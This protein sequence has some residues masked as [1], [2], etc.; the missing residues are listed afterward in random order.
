[1]KV[2]RAIR[3]TRN[4]VRRWWW[5]A[6]GERQR[7]IEERDQYK[8]SSELRFRQMVEYRDAVYTLKVEHRGASVDV[9]RAVA[10]RIDCEPG[11]ARVSPMDWTTGVSEC[12]LSDRGECP[13]DDACQLRELAAALETHASAIEARSDA[14][15]TGAA[16]GESAVAQPDAQ[17][18]SG[19]PS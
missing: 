1:M 11:C 12:P 17:T 19:D 6:R 8:A 15:G 5:M 3:D 2:G 16:V 18:P 13:F 4:V 10:D 14:T 9:L 7:I